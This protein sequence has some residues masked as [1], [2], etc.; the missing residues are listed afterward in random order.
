MELFYKVQKPPLDPGLF[1][2]FTF[3]ELKVF[4]PI[5]ISGHLS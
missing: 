4:F 5:K 3:V 2:G 1:I